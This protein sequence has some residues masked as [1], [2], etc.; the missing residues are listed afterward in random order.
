MREDFFDSE[1]VFDYIGYCKNAGDCLKK[2]F[3]EIC[4]NRN[5]L[6]ESCLKRHPKKYS[7]FGD[8]KFLEFCGYHHEGK[9]P[10]Q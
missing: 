5:C 1:C 3:Q 7:T 4:K 2:H 8:S 10:M 9:I 6:G